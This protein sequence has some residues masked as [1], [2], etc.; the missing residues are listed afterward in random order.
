M[1]SQ[2]SSL[3]EVRMPA[4]RLENRT[5]EPLAVY[6]PKLEGASTD[7]SLYVLLP[8]KVTLEGW[9][10]DG[11]YVP[12]DRVASQALSNVPGPLAIKYFGTGLIMIIN[13]SGNKYLMPFNN[14]AFKP[15]EVCCPSNYPTCVCWPIPNLA[16]DQVN[17][18]P[19]V[20][21]AD[22]PA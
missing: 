8:G 20:P 18:F 13:K 2:R 5:G 7:N 17:R 3:A 19:L 21:G 11:V 1:I 12:N 14:G 15:S 22:D 10:C 4:G 9:D 16:A 6:G